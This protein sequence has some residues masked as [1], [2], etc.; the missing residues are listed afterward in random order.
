M[1]KYVFPGADASLPLAW[2]IKQVSDLSGKP[3][4]WLTTTA[5]I[6][7]FRDQVHRRPRRALLGHALPVVP[8]LGVEQ[9]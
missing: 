4:S 6:R 9:G 3:S 2:V 5:R 8:E 7:K 1:N